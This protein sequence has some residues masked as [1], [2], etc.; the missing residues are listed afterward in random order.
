MIYYIFILIDR[1][2]VLRKIGITIFAFHADQISGIQ[3]Q[4]GGYI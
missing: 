2:A 4:K 1:A 3:R